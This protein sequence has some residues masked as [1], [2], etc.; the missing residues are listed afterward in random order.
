MWSQEGGILLALQAAGTTARPV[1]CKRSWE[2]RKKSGMIDGGSNVWGCHIGHCP[3]IGP[4][5]LR[6][7]RVMYIGSSRFDSDHPLSHTHRRPKSSR[8][9]SYSSIVRLGLNVGSCLTRQHLEYT[10]TGPRYDTSEPYFYI[11]KLVYPG[12]VQRTGMEDDG[13][14]RSA[15]WSCVGLPA[16]QLPKNAT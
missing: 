6:T 2:E 13:M 5:T 8:T 10:V 11:S 16:V 14:C 15:L 12:I 7:R 9:S 4:C 3:S 1:L